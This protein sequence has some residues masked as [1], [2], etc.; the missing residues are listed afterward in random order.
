MIVGI[1][2]NKSDAIYFQSQNPNSI[3]KLKPKPEILNW[4]YYKFEK[5]EFKFKLKNK[6]LNRSITNHRIQISDLGIWF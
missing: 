6:N 5:F 4:I 3:P 1:F 2:I